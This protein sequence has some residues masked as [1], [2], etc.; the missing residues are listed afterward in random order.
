MKEQRAPAFATTA[1]TAIAF[2]TLLE[3]AGYNLSQFRFLRHQQAAATRGHSV[4]ELWRDDHPAF[5]A[6]QSVQE[7]RA[8]KMLVNSTHWASFIGTPQGETMFVGLYRAKYLGLSSTDLVSQTTGVIDQAGSLHI[9]ELNE[10]P[11]FRDFVGRL[12]IDWGDAKR[13]RI[14]R[15]DRKPKAIVEIKR[16]FTEPAFPGYLELVEN[17]SCIFTLPIGW[18]AALRAAR[19]VYVLTCPRTKEIY[20]GSATG[21][22]G[23]FGRFSEYA[24]DG[25]GGNVQLKSRD[26]SDY[27]VSILAVA[28]SADTT[29]DVLIMENRWKNKLQT[30]AMGL[31]SN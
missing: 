2:N 8:H 10:L 31:N 26:R 15:G 5:E 29:Q 16:E 25:H 23:F 27:Q 28:G 9:Y 6:Y 14:Q 18:I 12:F 4:Y 11:D 30:R 3:I 1:T 20:I 24:R 17:L 7:G 13:A 22:E 19:G 21:D